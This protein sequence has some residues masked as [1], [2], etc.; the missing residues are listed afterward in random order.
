MVSKPTTQ[1]KSQRHLLLSALCELRGLI[2]ALETIETIDPAEL[3]ERIEH[4]KK[5]AKEFEDF[6]EVLK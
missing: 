1:K 6:I 3:K 4:S 2:E 5:V